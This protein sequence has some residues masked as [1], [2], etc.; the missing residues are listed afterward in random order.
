MK[1][2]VVKRFGLVT[3]AVSSIVLTGLTTLTAQ[4]IVKTNSN[5]PAPTITKVERETIE[6]VIREY[7]L[8]NPSIIREATQALQIQ[9]EKERQELVAENLKALESDIYFDPDSPVGG[10]VKGD[11]TVVVFFDYNCG[12]C[13]SNVPALRELVEKD[14]SLRIIYKEFP[15]MGP[16]SQDAALAALAAARQGK[17][18]EFHQ[19]LMSP[20]S[21]GEN[22]IK[23][24]S[25]NLGLDFADLQSDMADPKLRE[26][27]DRNIR[28]ANILG[29]NGT[30]G[31]IVGT[32]IIPGAI[33]V[34]SLQILVAGE[35]AKNES[36]KTAGKLAGA[37]K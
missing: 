21:G 8:A 1:L 19:A 22:M 15:I 9:E 23:D 30:P 6:L 35:R 14:P 31:Y 7:L 32:Q 17:Y 2:N 37:L 20:E 27:L 13:K 33:D 24:V 16:H 36:A 34:T 11:V 3:I 4:D 18:S 26:A 28:L 25:D 10:N 29:I 5:S 12:Y